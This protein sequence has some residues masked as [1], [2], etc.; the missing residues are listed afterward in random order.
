MEDEWGYNFY[1]ESNLR[2][3]TWLVFDVEAPVIS[4][5]SNITRAPY[6]EIAKFTEVGNHQLMK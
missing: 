1:F 5:R 2:S 4:Q 6:I 3:P